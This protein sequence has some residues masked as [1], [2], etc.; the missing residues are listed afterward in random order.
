MQMANSDTI[1]HKTKPNSVAWV[2][3]R[4]T[5]TVRP[6]LVGEVS[7]KFADRGCHVVSVTDPYIRI[8]GSVD[9]SRYF[10]FQVT[11]Q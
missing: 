5:P 8:L 9:R 3:E 2:R 7:V 4:T 10:F 6:P 11:P 1:C